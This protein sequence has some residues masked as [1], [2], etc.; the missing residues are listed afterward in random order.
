M[1]DR[2]LDRLQEFDERSKGYPIRSTVA[3]RVPRS[4]TWG[5][6]AHHD[7]GREGACVGFAWAHELT[8]RPVVEPTTEADALRLYR[9]AQML[10]PWPGEAYDGTSVLAGAKAVMERGGLISYRWAF[11]LEDLI[12]AVGFNGPA[13]LGVNW[14]SGMWDVDTYGYL[15]VTGSVV[16]GHAILCRGVS[17]KTESFLLHNSWGVGWGRNGTARIT[18]DDMRRLLREDGEACCPVRRR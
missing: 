16:G 18:F 9:R 5:C 6:H 15:R 17:V 11:S 2:V 14:Y 10:D 7:Q 12:L 4:Y 3:D 8:A 13:V 1:T